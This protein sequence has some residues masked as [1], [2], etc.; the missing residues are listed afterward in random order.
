MKR[1][2]AM[3]VTLGMLGVLLLPSVALASETENYIGDE[4][5]PGQPFESFESVDLLLQN[6]IN[7]VEHNRQILSNIMERLDTTSQRVID[8]LK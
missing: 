6:V 7:R 2:I 1:I 3:A 5:P 4:Y 8:N